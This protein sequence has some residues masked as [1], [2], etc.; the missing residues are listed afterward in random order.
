[1]N[2]FGSYPPPNFGS[3]P[4]SMVRPPT[5][6][7][8][9]SNFQPSMWNWYE[10]PSEPWSYNGQGEHWNGG[11]EPGRPRGSYGRNF[12]RGHGSGR[13]DY[14]PP[15]NQ[16][17]K[18][19]KKEPVFSHF[20]DPCDRGF[21]NQDKYDEHVS[22]H[23]KCSVEDCSF[24]AH[25]KLVN[26]HWKNN[27]APGAK[28]IKLDTEEEISKWREERRRN[29]PTL[30]N[31]EK[32]RKVMDAREERGAVLETAQFG[33]MRGRGRGQR[34]GRFRRGRGS[35][36][37]PPHQS[38]RPPPLTQSP[39]EGDPLGALANSDPD[40]DPEEP[41][42]GGGVTVPPK[43]MTSGLG[44]LMASYGSM[45][46]SDSDQEPQALPIQR[47]SQLP[48]ENQAMLKALPAKPQNSASS[49][50]K[51]LYPEPP[52][53]PQPGSGPHRPGR[54]GGARGGRNN[55][56]TPQ[57]RRATLLEMLLAPDVR[58]ER[59]VLL[60][61]VRYIVRNNFFELGGQTQDQDG[62]RG[63]TVTTAHPNLDPQTQK[64]R[65]DDLRGPLPATSV[66]GPDATGD[67]V[68][69]SPEGTQ[70]PP[71]CQGPSEVD[72]LNGEAVHPEEI[73][74]AASNPD[75]ITQPKS[76]HE[77]EVQGPVAQ[78]AG[79]DQSMLDN[80][81]NGPACSQS[82]PLQEPPMDLAVNAGYG[83]G[84]PEDHSQTS[85]YDDEVWET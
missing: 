79:E 39:R 54:G 1:M 72:I 17:K 14:G 64:V 32:K 83:D 23:V 50:A 5:F 28:R 58:H 62:T 12:H 11:P 65:S 69:S 37:G 38:E 47:T 6:H 35:R 44:S 81:Q 3:P 59:N 21:K 33:R 4:G 41:V 63:R 53:E 85:N 45:S 16:W 26:I 66:V 67:Q 60:Q 77:P 43:Q 52:R 36:P 9:P 34:G 20:C 2:D 82:H 30:V 68:R 13:Q 74:G 71:V 19:N 18:K 76:S 73:P 57:Q 27:H 24:T 75:V 10:P 42:S 80:T 78:Q 70:K 46:D 48:K 61:C 25:E 31:V 40:S 22:Q 49:G 56:D 8:P 84:H 15:N 29:Y 7:P 51:R 55:M